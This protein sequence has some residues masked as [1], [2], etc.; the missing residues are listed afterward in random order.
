MRQRTSPTETAAAVVQPPPIVLTS[1]RNPIQLQRRIKGIVWASF[2]IRKTR[3]G[4]R[5]VTKEMAN[6]S[7]IQ[8]YLEKTAFP[9]LPFSQSQKN[10]LKRSCF[11]FSTTL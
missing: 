2:E 11:T 3:S 7:A 1:T 6:F 5:I 9:I 10:P 8:N 4:A